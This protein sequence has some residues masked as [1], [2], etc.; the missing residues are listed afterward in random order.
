MK[1]EPCRRTLKLTEAGR[2]LQL[3]AFT[4]AER[5]DGF[6]PRGSI[7]LVD[8]LGH[9]NLAEIRIAQEFRAIEKRAPVSFHGQMD[10]IRGSVPGFAQIVTFQNVQRLQHG[11]ATRAGWRRADDV[12]P[13]IGP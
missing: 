5:I 8:E 9:G 10:G 4:G 11:D 12:V 1:L 7:L 6:T 2:P 3:F 13:T